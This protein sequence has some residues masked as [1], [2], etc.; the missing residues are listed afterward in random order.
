MVLDPRSEFSLANSSVG[1]NVIIFGFDM[2]LSVHIHNKKKD[3]LILGKGPTQGLYDTM[4]TAEAQYSINFSRPNRRFC[5]S[6]HYNDSNSFL[7]ANDTKI[8][9]FKAKDSEIKKY[10]CLGDIPRDFSANNMK[11]KGL[12]GCVYNFSVGYRAFGTSNIID[13]HKYLMKKPYCSLK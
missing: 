9:H 4:L 3:V 1:Q 10:L 7:F 13:I 6:L 11:K 8:Y 2:S 12:N 5:L